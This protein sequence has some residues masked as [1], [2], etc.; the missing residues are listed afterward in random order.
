MANKFRDISV[1]EYKKLSEEEQKNFKEVIKKTFLGLTKRTMENQAEEAR[2]ERLKKEANRRNFQV[3]SGIWKQ[4]KIT[5]TAIRVVT[6][7]WGKI[8][9]LAIFLLP[10]KF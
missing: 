7:N 6:K 5:S 8:L 4:S 3:M 2:S 1:D 10:K 9:G